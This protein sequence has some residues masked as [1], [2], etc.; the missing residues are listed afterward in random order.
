[1]P[2]LQEVL[3]TFSFLPLVV[4]ECED[5]DVA[6]VLDVVWDDS[7]T[8]IVVSTDL[9]HFQSYARAREIDEVTSNAI[10]A[11]RP[12]WIGEGQA[13]GRLPVRGLLHCASA[14]Q[15]QPELL[16][17][18]NSGDTAGP[19]DRVVGYGAYRFLPKTRRSE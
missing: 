1:L 17:L 5:A 3:G 8:L 9:S 2:F 7:Q 19:R 14:R 15:L 6:H 11:L 10:L 13:C 16:Y 18:R 4:S 12:E